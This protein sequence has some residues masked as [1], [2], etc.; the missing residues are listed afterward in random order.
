MQNTTLA[1]ETKTVEISN[2]EAAARTFTLTDV[3]YAN[4][5]IEDGE[6]TLSE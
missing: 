1:Q 6:I 3:N 4:L 2:P 5:P